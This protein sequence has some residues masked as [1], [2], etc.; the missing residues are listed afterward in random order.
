[1]MNL[2]NCSGRGQG[3]CCTI[4]QPIFALVKTLCLLE[5]LI[6]GIDIIAAQGSA[7]TK[8]CLTYAPFGSQQLPSV[9]SNLG[10][11]YAFH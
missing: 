10:G 2:H 1:M 4:A 7:A 5:L 6:S 9:M 3:R 11:S 8:T